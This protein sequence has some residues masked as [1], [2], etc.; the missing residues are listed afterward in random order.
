MNERNITPPADCRTGP[1]ILI[2][3]LAALFLLMYQPFLNG[4]VYAEFDLR[5]QFI[6]W[7]IFYST[8]LDAGDPGFWNPHLYRGYDHL[9]EGQSGLLHPAHILL[10]ALADVPFA[11]MCEMALYIPFAAAG[12]VMWLRRSFRLNQTAALFGGGAF[13][14]STFFYAHY[15]HVNLLWIAAHL[16]WLLCFA[17]T[18]LRSPSNRTA[19][20]LLIVTYTSMWL[21]GHPQMVWINSVAIAGL[22]AYRFL[23]T[24]SSCLPL[25]RYGIVAWCVVAGTAIGAAQLLPTYMYFQDSP[26]SDLSDLERS[27]FSLHPLNLVVSA[28][29][30]LFVDISVGDY[31]YNG[32]NAPEFMN[33]HQE[34]PAYFGI[35]ILA[36]IGSCCILHRH[37]VFSRRNRVRVSCVAAALLA[38]ILLSCGRYGGLDSVLDLL[39]LVSHFRA[40]ARYRLL[41]MLLIAAVGAVAVHVLMTRCDRVRFDRRTIFYLAASL[42]VSGIVALYAA[43]TPYIPFRSTRLFTGAA[44]ALVIGP[45]LHGTV[46]VLV[47]L[48]HRSRRSVTAVLCSLCLFDLGMFG[49]QILERSERRSIEDI[50]TARA[51]LKTSDKSYRHVSTLNEPLWTGASLAGGYLGLPVDDPLDLY[52]NRD[53]LRLAS[54]RFAH[55]DRTIFEINDY[56]PRVRLAAELRSGTANLEH[57]GDIDLSHTVLTSDADAAP[58]SG[59]AISSA[60]SV[61]VESETPSSMIA[62][63]DVGHARI[64]VISDRWSPLWQA[65]VDGVSRAIIPLFDYTMRGI[66]VSP[67]D[68]V[69][70]MQYSPRH[71]MRSMPCVC[72]GI[73]MTFALLMYQNRRAADGCSPGNREVASRDE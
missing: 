15:P 12:M 19:P 25:R 63:V 52:G 65:K 38:S 66:M 16:P 40:P 56:L 24:Q 5:E 17:D 9:G 22:L 10:Y 3:T 72:L 28:A 51:L 42:L 53:H 70:A 39:P 60:E 47:V 1:A 20:V 23:T 41:T 6:P 33:S 4:E 14:F 62:R 55:G 67:D 59:P 48:I 34:F 45:A 7:R 13:S 2:V 26:R 8:C 31:I 35:A 69:V 58:L 21:L 11:I 57:T 73:F 46:L 18:C 27:N 68:D 30:R 32:D 64:L 50:T 37:A 36:L 44:A 49:M 61:V 29:P 43:L 71:L 54:V